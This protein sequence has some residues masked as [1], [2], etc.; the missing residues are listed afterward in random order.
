[1]NVGPPGACSAPLECI[2]DV[3]MPQLSLTIQESAPEQ[4]GPFGIV[5]GKERKRG[6]E[7]E[8][9]EGEGGRKGERKRSLKGERERVLKEW[10]GVIKR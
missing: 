8:H 3:E 5:V 7:R 9:L 1:M 4:S 6:R 2:L 10:E